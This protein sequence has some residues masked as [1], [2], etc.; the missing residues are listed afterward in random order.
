MTE[1]ELSSQV[2]LSIHDAIVF[3]SRKHYKQYRKSTD[4]PYISHIMEVMQILIEN[5][6]EKEVIIAGILH[7]TI[8]DTETTREEIKQLFGEKILSIVQSETEDKSLDWFERKSITI[9]NL[10][11]ASIEEKL[12]LCAD[13]LSNIRFIYSDLK[14]IGEKVWERFNAPKNKIEWYYKN[15]LRELSE[16]SELD[17]YDNLSELIDDVFNYAIMDKT[18]NYKESPVFY[19]G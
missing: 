12:V 15:I 8:E 9:K 19:R 14:T 10:P 1:K 2:D 5:K 16:I 13:K 17:M 3:A 7:D 11:S 18:P 4:M 6:C